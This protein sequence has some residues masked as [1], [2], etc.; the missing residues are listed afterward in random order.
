MIFDINSDN[1][2]LFADSETIKRY[3]TAGKGVVTLVAPSGKAHS[4]SFER[5]KNEKD[6]DED[7][8]FV[9]TL[10]EGRK[11]YTGK[12]TYGKYFNLTRNS[13]FDPETEAVKGAM[14]ITRMAN[15]Q[16]LVISTPMKLYH[17]DKCAYC[18]TTLRSKKAIE[19][20]LGRVCYKRYL[21]KLNRV[22]YN[23]NS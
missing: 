10:H 6:F 13:K 21:E 17:T 19:L 12:F 11:H 15:D 9:Y 22:K 3:I 16:S 8:I 5:P 2:T 23:G 7:T 14:F 4:Y 20:G 1:Y 18:G